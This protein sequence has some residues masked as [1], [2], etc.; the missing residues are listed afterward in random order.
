[1]EAGREDRTGGTIPRPRKERERLASRC[2]LAYAKFGVMEAAVNEIGTVGD[3]GRSGWFKGGRKR[4]IR[5]RGEVEDRTGEGVEGVAH[6]SGLCVADEDDGA[7]VV[8]EGGAEVV[9]SGTV[10]GPGGTG[11]RGVMGNN[12][13]A[14]G[15]KGIAGEVNGGGKQA[16]VRRPGR[17]GFPGGKVIEG[18]FSVG[19][20]AVPFSEG[21]VD[22][23]GGKNR[24]EVILERA[25]VPFG[26]IR[27]VIP[28][29]YKLNVRTGDDRME[30]L[31]EV[32]GG[33]I[34]SG[35]VGDR[36]TTSSKESKDGFK[37]SDVRGGG[38][39]WHRHNVGIALVRSNEYVLV[40]AG[41]FDGEPPRQ[42][43]EVPVGT[44]KGADVGCIGGGVKATRFN[45]GREG[46]SSGGVKATRCSRC[47]GGHGDGA[48]E[49]SR[50]IRF[51]GGA[52]VGAYEIKV[53]EGSVWGEWRI[54]KDEGSREAGNAAQEASTYSTDEGGDGGRAKGAMMVSNEGG[55]G[56]FVNMGD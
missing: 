47:R 1:M 23:D 39:G 49:G 5:E 27:T 17:V 45:G 35:K 56:E 53:A 32:G 19:K 25:N 36:V 28:G 37:G 21:E 20:E 52:D 40:T 7:A 12:E 24:Y 38:T 50:R 9:A 22:V 51:A 34:V 30:V 13:L 14:R 33:L 15:V 55:V 2:H 48:E 54:A 26:N 18:E 3:R 10:L 8:G 29:G 6:T 41:R 16:G 42:V 44:G 43:G 11:V 46:V 4:C 31:G